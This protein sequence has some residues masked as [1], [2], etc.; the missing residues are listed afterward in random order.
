M[1]RRDLFR[2][3]LAVPVLSTA[4]SKKPDAEPQKR[5]A[6]EPE[7][8]KTI[9][10]NKVTVIDHDPARAQRIAELIR[11]SDLRRLR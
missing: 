10:V 6:P 5:P 8:T 1:N 2:G 7:R 3:A 9:V 4:P 11:L